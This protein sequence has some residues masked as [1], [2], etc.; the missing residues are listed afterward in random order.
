MTVGESN[1]KLSSLRMPCNHTH[2]VAAFTAP[3]Y[4][5]SY[6]EREIMCYL[7]LEKKMGPLESMNTK[8]EVEFMSLVSPAQSESENPTSSSGELAT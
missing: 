2:C 8:L 6:E 1:A 3:L 7:L 4:S 5:T